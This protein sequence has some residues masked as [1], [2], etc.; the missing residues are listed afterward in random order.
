[1]SNHPCCVT[2]LA[3]VILLECGKTYIGVIIIG[4]YHRSLTESPSFEAVSVH[5]LIIPKCVW[6]ELPH[7]LLT[8]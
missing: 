1:M 8:F 4:I 6:V 3:L 7:K 2:L 5:F